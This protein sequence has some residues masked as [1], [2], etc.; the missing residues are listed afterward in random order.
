[1][2]D[3]KISTNN[4]WREFKRRDEVPAEI[5]AGQFDWTI[6]ANEEHDDYSDGFLEYRG[7]WYHLGDFMVGAPDPW[8]GAHGDSFFSGVFIRV[9]DD[10][11]QY[12]IATYTQ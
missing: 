8:Q 3:M 11:E 9:S 4:Q 7:T 5:L 12:K 6:K 10:G 1:M 2:N